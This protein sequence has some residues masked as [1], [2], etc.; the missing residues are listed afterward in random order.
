M[1]AAR[2]LTA[3]ALAD[4]VYLVGLATF[5]VGAVACLASPDATVLDLSSGL[6]GVGGA[7][8]FSAGAALLSVRFTGP[9]RAFAFATFGTVVA[10]G[11]A[12]ARCWRAC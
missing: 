3:G 8:I 12:A 10:A 5:A 2:L 4:R 6:M 7:I 9:D 11:A 1:G